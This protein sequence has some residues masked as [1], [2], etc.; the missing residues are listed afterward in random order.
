M[1]QAA[2]GRYRLTQVTPPGGGVCDARATPGGMLTPV[3][4]WTYDPLL[5]VYVLGSAGLECLGNGHY[6]CVN[7]PQDIDGTCVFLGP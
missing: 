7:G 6:R 5:D 2:P 3:G 1:P 4:F